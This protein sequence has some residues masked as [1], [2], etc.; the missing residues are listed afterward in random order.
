MQSILRY[1][2]IIICL[3]ITMVLLYSMF[4]PYLYAEEDVTPKEE[5][6]SVVGG[7]FHFVGEVVA[8]PFRV[9]GH[10]FDLIF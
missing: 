5:E 1:Q 6:R 3:L 4:L 2:P 9:I 7:L 8:F 10:G